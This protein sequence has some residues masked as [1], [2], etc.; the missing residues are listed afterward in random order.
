[1]IFPSAQHSQTWEILFKILNFCDPLSFEHETVLYSSLFSSMIKFHAKFFQIVVG[2]LFG[3]S[4]CIN[5]WLVRFFFIFCFVSLDFMWICRLDEKRREK[6]SFFSQTE[7]V[8]KGKQQKEIK[9]FSKSAR[10]MQIIGSLVLLIFCC[11]RNGSKISRKSCSVSI[12]FQFTHRQ[13]EGVEDSTQIELWWSW[14]LRD[15]TLS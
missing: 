13:L 7:I 8:W 10:H 12:Q 5:Y 14:M 4:C 9:N 1:M 3:L 15:R 11:M 6:K 2:F